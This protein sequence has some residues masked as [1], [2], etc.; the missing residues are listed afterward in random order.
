VISRD[1]ANGAR[2]EIATR[3]DGTQTISVYTNGLLRSVTEKRSD[4]LP[5]STRNM[6]YDVLNRP[7]STTE[8]AA[9]G[10][11][12]TTVN[13]YN[14]AGAVT[15]VTVSAGAL[16]QTTTHE[17]DAMGRR[18]R[19]ILP[20][21]GVVNYGYNLQG[22][23][24]NQS[25]ARTYPVT[26]SYTDQGRLAS[27]STYRSGPS[28][29]ADVTAWQYD[30]ARGWLTSKVYADGSVNGYSYFANGALQKRN[31]ARGVKT[32]YN[33]DNAGSLTNIS[34]S[35][36]TPGVS[37]TLDRLGRAVEI[38]D[39]VGTWT[40][41]FNEDGTLASESTGGPGA[42]PTVIRS[43]DSLARLTNISLSI[44]GS[45]SVATMYSFDLAGRISTVSDGISTATYTYGPDGA[46]GATDEMTWT[47]LSFGS[48]L[49]TRR[50]FDGLNRLTSVIN[51]PSASS[52]TSARYSYNQ[53]N[54]KTTNTLAD[55]SEWRYTYDSL[56]QV[57]SGR[58]YSSAGQPVQG[59]Q[60]E[61]NFDTIGNRTLV[62]ASLADARSSAYTA[63]NL[64]QYT[65]RT[66]PGVVNV[67]GDAGLDATVSVRLGTNNAVAVNRDG[68]YFWKELEVDN[69]FAIFSTTN[70]K[71]TAY[72]AQG[73]NSLVR[74]E[75]V[76]AKVPMTPER[77]TWDADGNLLSD[78][79]W[80]NTWNGEN[81]LIAMESLPSV[82]DIMKKRLIFQ[83]DYLGRRVSKKIYSWGAD[84]WSLITDYSFVWD[85]WNLISELCA[86]VPLSLCYTNSYTWGLDLSGTLQGAGGV[87]GL[88]FSASSAN[89]ARNFFVYDGNG[90]V[91]GLVD[92]NGV[93]V[94]EYEYSPF[95]ETLKA[96]GNIGLENKF[97]F[98]TKYT[99][100]ETG[101]LSYGYRYY[102][103]TI[104]RWIG[105]DPIQEEGGENLYVFCGN[106]P[107]N[108]FD[109]NGLYLVA[110]DGTG[111]ADWSR[112]NLKTDKFNSHVANFYKDYKGHGRFWEGPNT[113]GGGVSATVNEA[114]GAI[115][116][117]LKKYG[118]DEPL[119][120]VG[121]SRGGFIAILVAQKLKDK[122][123]DKCKKKEIDFLGL[124]DAVD[125]YMGADANIIP[126]NV[127]FT[128]HGR[129]DLKVGSRTS[130]GNTGTSG[131]K[132]YEQD[133]FY[134]THSAMGG[135]PWKGDHPKTVTKEQDEEASKKIDSWIRTKAKANGVSL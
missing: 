37:Y 104:G 27:M 83:Y 54:Q 41:K 84:H 59:A 56:G 97:R 44:G 6:A 102:Y 22:A 80:T 119:F 87:G 79:L 106:E 11:T 67:A 107:M 34:Y 48:A 69:S 60:F 132:K 17:F 40:N 19:T 131:S 45:R 88:L 28:G 21:N 57:I 115:C 35:D 126:D 124:Y 111:S 71:V 65:Q 24:T 8:S 108:K 12:R 105:R 109:V 127:K 55:A 16:S 116:E 33:Y 73:S 114:Y 13:G 53:A 42:P 82:P 89:S 62:G 117:A 129:R 134:G 78:G 95:G 58:K 122:P 101:L 50:T 123:C 63:N 1:R 51:L 74:T 30:P 121:H 85:G 120:L 86:S 61:Y 25:G 46:S 70:L 66:V 29:P 77:F 3:P 18:I 68:K 98:S 5:G 64:N 133:F 113:V 93:T 112:F 2:T 76:S 125:M 81:R 49:N 90:N 130:W 15:S 4:G 128:A 36:G 72:M 110:I 52:A 103:P 118:N 10:E 47:N 38:R 20:D 32:T 96:T 100:S 23:L 99:D 26:Y 31:W 43:Y 75:T 14:A 39:A 94:A 91:T 135:D 7:S 92:T 9:N